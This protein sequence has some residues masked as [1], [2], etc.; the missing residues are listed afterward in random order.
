[1]EV[2]QS[3]EYLV[4]CARL[5][6]YLG[7]PVTSLNWSTVALATTKQGDLSGLAR[8]HYLQGKALLVGLGRR[9]VYLCFPCMYV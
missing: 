5:H 1:M 6:L 7:E 2:V 4:C 3:T 8:L 9:A